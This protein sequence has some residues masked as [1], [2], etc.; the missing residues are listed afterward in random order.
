MRDALWVG[1]L[2]VFVA[3]ASALVWLLAAQQ[4]ATARER[5]QRRWFAGTLASVGDG[6]AYE[7][8]RNNPTNTKPSELLTDMLHQR[9][10]PVLPLR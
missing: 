8:Y 4:R 3:V 2:A 7:V 5:E 10:A 9:G 1:P 6:V